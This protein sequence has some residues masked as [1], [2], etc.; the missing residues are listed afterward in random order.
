MSASRLLAQWLQRQIDPAAW[1]WLDARREGLG[2]AFTDRD[3]HVTL[4]MIPRRL[5]KSDLT[6][7]AADLAGAS[8]SRA[9]WDPRGWSVDE[10]ARVLVL[11]ETAGA[12]GRRFG[13]RF[14]D[15][16]RN[17]DVGELIA[18]YRGLPLY[19][20]PGD[21]EE[22]AAEGL[23]TN[24]RAVFEAVAHAS[25]YPREAFDESRWNQMVLKA[26]FVGSTLAPIQGLD[27]RA[28]PE[29]ATILCDYAHERWAAG[30]PVSPE[31]WRCVGPFCEGAMIEDLTRVLAD[32][33]ERERRA[34]GL[35]LAASPSPDAAR[36]LRT[37]PELLREV[38]AGA[39]GWTELADAPR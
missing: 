36:V 9:G 34:A 7:D 10:A 33:D 38:E 24:M 5:G 18:F 6:L 13:E 3:L 22:Q 19:P 21:L 16:C 28:N 32:G 25:P 2:E 17:A 31:L 20:D 23:R 8:A 4:G 29:L 12:G 26:L 35:A 15:L 37:A 30:R 14:A 1:T 39:F 27:E 11:L